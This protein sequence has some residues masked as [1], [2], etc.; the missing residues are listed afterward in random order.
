M[1]SIMIKQTSS[2]VFLIIISSV[3]LVAGIAWSSAFESL[4]EDF[5]PE[6]LKKYHRL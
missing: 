5:T 6:A 3:S 2:D 1:K 4:F